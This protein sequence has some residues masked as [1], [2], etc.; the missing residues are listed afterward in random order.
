MLV[1]WYCQHHIITSITSCHCRQEII[2]NNMSLSESHHCQYIIIASI[3]WLSISHMHITYASHMHHIIATI[4]ALSASY[5][6]HHH[7]IVIIA[8]LSVS[9][10]YH[11]QIIVSIANIISLSASNNCQNHVIAN[12]MPFLWYIL[13]GKSWL[14]LMVVN[15]IHNLVTGSPTRVRNRVN[16]VCGRTLVLLNHIF[17]NLFMVGMTSFLSIVYR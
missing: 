10:H 17:F 11:H 5:H 8:S 6:V 9:H 1:S 12:I 16:L 2:A 4:I 15:E 13:T 7:A 14:Y 3:T